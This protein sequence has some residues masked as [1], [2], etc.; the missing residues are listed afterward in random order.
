MFVNANS[1]AQN[2]FSG[3]IVGYSKSSNIVNTVNFS[4]IVSETSYNNS[5]GSIS[6]ASGIVGFDTLDSVGVTE[7]NHIV[8]KDINSSTIKYSYNIGNIIAENSCTNGLG[9]T[10]KN[11][12]VQF[13][14]D[15]I[16]NSY[17]LE[18]DSYTSNYDNQSKTLEKLKNKDTFVDWDF[19]RV[20]NI[21]ND[22]TPNLRVFSKKI[23]DIELNVDTNILNTNSEYNYSYTFTQLI[24]LVMLI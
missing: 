11:G 3:G 15:K 19:I 4:K 17:Y 6:Y 7:N 16:S 8:Y 21:N 1:T 22:S 2:T 23:E 20:W 9:K 13:T 10:I 14:S 24:H 18:D 12:L 5:S